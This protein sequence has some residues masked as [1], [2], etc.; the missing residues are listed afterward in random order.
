MGQAAIIRMA[1]RRR[2]TK[3]GSYPAMALGLSGS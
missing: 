2:A 3:C 1:N